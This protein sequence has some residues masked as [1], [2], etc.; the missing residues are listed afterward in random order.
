MVT[1]QLLYYRSRLDDDLQPLPISVTDDGT[2]PKALVLFVV[3]GTIKD[4]EKSVGRVADVAEVI[5]AS[6]ESAV[7]AMPCGRGPGSVFQ[8]PGEVDLFEVVNFVCG[9]YAIDRDRISVTGT[10][11]G[12]AGTWY[13]ASH[14][15]D[16]FSAAVPVCGYC[17]YRLWHKPGGTIMPTLPWEHPSWRA[18]G[19]AFRPGNVANM[20]LWIVHGAWDTAL[21]GGVPVEHSRQMVRLLTENGVDH[22]YTEV[23][24]YGHGPMPDDIRSSIL[25][26]MCRQVRQHLPEKIDLTAH[27]LRH[28]SSHYLRLD[29][30]E[31]YGSP[32]RAS[33]SLKI[34]QLVITETENLARV[35]L[36]PLPGKD[37][38][39]VSIE[40][41]EIG[42]VD[43][44]QPVVFQK[45]GETWQ[46]TDSLPEGEKIEG[47]SGPVG[48]IFFEPTRLIRGTVGGDEETFCQ[49]WLAEHMAK[50]FK[51]SN[52]GVH[53]GDFDGES[54]YEIPVLEDTVCTEADLTECN[55][56]LLGNPASNG[57]LGQIAGQLPVEYGKNELTFYGKR[58]QGEHLGLCYIQPSPFNPLRYIV[59]AGG[60]K[61]RDNPTVSHLNLQL[62]PDYLIWDSEKPLTWGFFDGNWQMV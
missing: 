26:W 43:L 20:A 1:R 27:T 13:L 7:V 54:C 19:A 25:P 57:V 40:S 47:C 32:A 3:P 31:R 49:K 9:I 29:A 10:S 30:F 21:G 51:K 24:A 58:F 61:T 59:V 44:S 42:L 5:A 36:G 39:S 50:H 52:G 4:L 56:I 38:Y 11:M 14:Y 33:V 55:L 28:N 15:P 46:K 16:V 53:R 60:T 23:P 35:A 45:S 41:S 2:D 18:R 8:G 62:L 6:G 37:A 17:D 48:D 34:N 22:Q 12:G